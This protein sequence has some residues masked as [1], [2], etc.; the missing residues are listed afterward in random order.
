MC[1]QITGK[2]CAVQKL[3]SDHRKSGHGPSESKLQLLKNAS[4]TGRVESLS[5]PRSSMGLLAARA[6][7]VQLMCS[8]Q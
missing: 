4:T 5:C 7:V 1:L 6:E 2:G 8:V 3:L